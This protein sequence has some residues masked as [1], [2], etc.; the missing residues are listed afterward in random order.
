MQLI[1][2]LIGL[3]V[4]FFLACFILSNPIGQMLVAIFVGFPV[5]MSIIIGSFK[6]LK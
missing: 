5:A 3:V 2:V 4:M 1:G 6:L